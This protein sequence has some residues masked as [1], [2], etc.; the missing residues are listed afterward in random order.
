MTCVKK[1]GLKNA[2]NPSPHLRLHFS[3]QLLYLCTLL[4]LCGHFMNRFCPVQ[5]QCYGLSK[6]RVNLKEELFI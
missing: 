6:P 1:E 5:A 3:P 2:S 4:N